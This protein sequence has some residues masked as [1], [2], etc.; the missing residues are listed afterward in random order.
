MIASQKVQAPKRNVRKL[1]IVG[2]VI[3]TIVVV[4][5]T[6]SLPSVHWVHPPGF[7]DY[8]KFSKRLRNVDSEFGDLD[9]NEDN[10]TID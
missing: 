6:S 9:S 1:L 2:D 5:I 8:V 7:E 4:I 3:C 10:V